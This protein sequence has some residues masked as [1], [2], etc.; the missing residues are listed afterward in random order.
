MMRTTVT[1]NLQL[2]A[3]LL[4]LSLLIVFALLQ[5][6][7]AAERA[8][9]LDSAGPG[10][11]RALRLWLEEMGYTVEQTGNQTFTLDAASDLLFVYPNAEPYTEDEARA[12]E[13]WVAA[14]HTLVLIGLARDE[15]A[16]QS[17]F[18]VPLD[19]GDDLARTVA[20]QQPLLPEAD[21]ELQHDMPASAVLDLTE[22]P[23]AVP[24]LAQTN[25]PTVAVQTLGQGT[26]WFLS[27]QHTLTNQALGVRDQAMLV[28][29]L[30]RTVPSGGQVLFDT[31]HLYGPARADAQSGAITSLQDW[32][33]RTPVGW[34]TLFGLGA[35]LLY[36]FLQG[37][38]LGPALPARNEVRRREAAEYVQAMAALH[39]RA[40][41]NEAVAH[42]HKRRLKLN[43][44]RTLRIN[45]TLPDR[46]FVQRLQ[47]NDATLSETQV[48]TINHLLHNLDQ[49]PDE[50]ALV[51]MV[52]EIDQILTSKR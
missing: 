9:D 34:A 20:Q 26:I 44:G 28:P 46:E 42:H 32:L 38:R 14:G 1:R 51:R 41:Q 2:I 11:L 13:R 25:G 19:F 45:P 5:G 35:T 21:A 36:L 31:Y 49:Q 33:Y 4:L 22:A 40:H 24:V 37:W 29:A 50:G 48:A 18:G 23:Q 6:E 47:E 8:F 12:L 27:L 39:R 30:L 3:S 10:G 15:T 43:L 7:P 52:A 17:R 16:L